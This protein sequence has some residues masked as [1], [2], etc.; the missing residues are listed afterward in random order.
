MSAGERRWPAVERKENAPASDLL[1]LL[2]LVFP[3]SLPLGR[4]PR[5]LALIGHL[6]MVYCAG[7]PTEKIVRLL[8][9]YTKVTDHKFLWFISR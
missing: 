3:L 9:Y 7:K 5:R 6:A 1:A 2:A 4:L 8:H